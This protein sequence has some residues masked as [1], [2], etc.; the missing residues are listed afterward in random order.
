MDNSFEML[1]LQRQAG[2]QEIRDC[3]KFSSQFGLVLKEA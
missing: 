1:K 3:N 2:L